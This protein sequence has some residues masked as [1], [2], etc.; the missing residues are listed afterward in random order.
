MRPTFRN[1]N[2]SYEGWAYRNGLLKQTVR[3]ERRNLIER[4]SD[5]RNDRLYRLSAQGRVQALGGRDPEERWGRRWDGRWRMVIFD[6]P[7]GRNAQRE[8]LRRYLRQQG[9]GYLQDSVWIT[10][11]SIEQER[12]VLVGGKI[13]VESLILMEARPCAGESDA[14]IVC[15]AWDFERI[16]RRYAIHL[17]VLGERPGRDRTDEEGGKSLL[18]WAKNEHQ[19]WLRAVSNDPLLPARILPANYLGRRAWRRRMQVLRDAGK[20]LHSLKRPGCMDT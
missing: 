13:D 12:R 16:N 19:A 4:K 8:R 14:E 7:T 11:D 10:P 9:F 2:E 5:S 20:Q 17:R 18:R 3:L 15:G 1:L 6:V